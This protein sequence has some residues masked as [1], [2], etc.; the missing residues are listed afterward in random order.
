MPV[1]VVKLPADSGFIRS[2][3]RLAKTDVID[4]MMPALFVEP[5]RPEARPLPEEAE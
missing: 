3:G 5:V 1:A 4:A 2:T